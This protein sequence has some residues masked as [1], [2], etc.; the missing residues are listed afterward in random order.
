[1]QKKVY[2]QTKIKTD[3]ASSGLNLELRLYPF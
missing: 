1:M 2:E 3:I